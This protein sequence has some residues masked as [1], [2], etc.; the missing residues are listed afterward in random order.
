MKGQL[1]KC[2]RRVLLDSNTGS[3]Q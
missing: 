3:R 2:G 1:D